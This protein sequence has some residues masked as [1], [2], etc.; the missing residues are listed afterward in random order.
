[1][2]AVSSDNPG[3]KFPPPLFFV[4]GFLAGYFVHRFHP[5]SILP[6]GTWR[7]PG[8]ILVVAGVALIADFVTRFR[9]AGT[10]IRPDQASTSLVTTGAFRFTRNPAYLGWVVIYLGASLWL[11]SLWPLLILPLVIISVQGFVIRREEWFLEQKFGDEYRAYK[12]RVR[13]WL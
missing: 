12:Q 7:L 10:T 4:L 6:P 3:V 2:S 1:M 9:R 11:N 13:R 8:I 5:V